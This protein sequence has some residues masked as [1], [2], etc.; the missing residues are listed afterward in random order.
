[1]APWF[2]IRWFEATVFL[3][4]WCYHLY[5][6]FW[7]IKFFIGRP[8][9]LHKNSPHSRKEAKHKMHW[10]FF[11]SGKKKSVLIVS[12]N[13]WPF[14]LN[15]CIS[16]V[17]CDLKGQ[18]AKPTSAE[19]NK[20]LQLHLRL[21]GVWCKFPISWS[22]QGSLVQKV[23]VGVLKWMAKGKCQETPAPSLE[24]CMF[25]RPCSLSVALKSLLYT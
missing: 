15:W 23:L 12:V 1:M 7:V 5:F 2:V 21:Q 11:Y 6:L 16:W 24:L 17:V 25:L 3:F 10:K 4:P 19:I 18:T 22:D 20:E 9:F 13:K 14:S 8:L